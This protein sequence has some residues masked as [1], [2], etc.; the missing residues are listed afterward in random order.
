MEEYTNGTAGGQGNGA[1]TGEPTGSNTQNGQAGN[2]ATDKNNQTGQNQDKTY[3]QEEFTSEVDR[4]V[5]EAIKTARGKWDKELTTKLEEAKAEGERVAKLTAEQRAAE[6]KANEEKAFSEK[7]AKLNREILEFET[8]KTLDAKGLPTDF[9]NML[10]GAD[11]EQTD[12][13][14]E[15]FEK[16]WNQKQQEAVEAKLRGSA[17]KGGKGSGGSSDPFLSGFNR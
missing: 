16:A 9:V 10:C 12:A 4:R 6:K 1:Q 8:K 7:Q 2:G 5:Q 14:I 17:P 3:T 11:K 15:A 13:N